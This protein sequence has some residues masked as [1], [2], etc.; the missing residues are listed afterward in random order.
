M[1]LRR[2]CL[3]VWWT[4]VYFV[5]ALAREWPQLL[6]AVLAVGVGVTMMLLLWSLFT[7]LTGG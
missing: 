2:F 3:D 4:F 7:V 5:R 1:S 6:A